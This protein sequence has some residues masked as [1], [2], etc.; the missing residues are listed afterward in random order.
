MCIRDRPW[1]FRS[2]C[3]GLGSAVLFAA[4]RAGGQRL[5]L[6]RGQW[7]RLWLLALLNITA[8]NML[9]AFG[10]ALI[11]SGRAAILAYTMPVW[12]V[13]LSIWLLGYRTMIAIRS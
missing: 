6:P 4:L 1:T 11:P 10:V 2:L 13:P 9:I 5:M 12:A 8:W 3:L 7:G